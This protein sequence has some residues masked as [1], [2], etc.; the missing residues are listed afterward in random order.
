LLAPP[1]GKLAIVA[2]KCALSGRLSIAVQPQLSDVRP[3]PRLF[4]HSE[5]RL[6]GKRLHSPFVAA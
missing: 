2:G 6:T 5:L 3:L 1:S 4:G